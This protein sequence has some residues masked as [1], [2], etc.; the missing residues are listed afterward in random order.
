MTQ[1]A[2]IF[3]FS[4]YFVSVIMH[5][6]A[7]IDVYILCLL[8]AFRQQHFNKRIAYCLSIATENSTVIN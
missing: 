4:Y 5:Y 1:C 8:L 6:C 7:L 3:C 2:S